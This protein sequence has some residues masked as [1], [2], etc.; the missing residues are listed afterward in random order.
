[1]LTTRSQIIEALCTFL[2]ANVTEFNLVK[3]Y[4]GELDRYSKKVQLKEDTFPAMVN[5]QTPFALII[6]KDRKRMESQGTSLKFRHDIS[7]YIGVQNTHNFASTEVPDIFALMTKC[8]DVLH[9]KT[10]FKGA[11]A[12]NVESDGEYLITSDL[13]TVYDQK[14][15]QLEIGR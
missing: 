15:Y 13:F 8:T 2:R 10:F 7:I 14:Y 11:G 1:M 4:H 3:P 6:S 12:L 5:L 9:G